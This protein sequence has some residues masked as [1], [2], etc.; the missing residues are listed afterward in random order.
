[1][2]D[3]NEEMTG[4]KTFNDFDFSKLPGMKYGLGSYVKVLDLGWET[5]DMLV[6]FS[7]AGIHTNAW[8]LVQD[9]GQPDFSPQYYKMKVSDDLRDLFLELAGIE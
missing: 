5:S 1:M 7:C 3:K 9:L 6:E 2:T 4:R 8:L